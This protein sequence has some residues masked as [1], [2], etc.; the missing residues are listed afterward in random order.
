[1][2]RSLHKLSLL[3]AL[4]A[5]I[6]AVVPASAQARLPRGFIG[7]TSEDVFAGDH[8]YRTANLNL[9]A[10]ARVGLTRQTFD[11]RKIETSPGVYDLSYHDAYVAEL[12]T[13]RM[14]VLPILF[15][16]PSF[17]TGTPVTRPAYPPSSNASMARFAQVLVN[18]YGPRG[19]LWRERPWLPRT[20]IT[21]WQ[22]WNEP[23]LPVYWQGRPNARAYARMVATVGRAIRRS[24]RRAEIVTAGLPP[25]TQQGAVPLKRYVK[26]LYR[27][28][29]GRS[30]NSL[31][32]NSYAR[33]KRELGRLLG[34]LRKQMNR[35]GGRRNSLWI[36]E[37]G[38]ATSGPRSRFTVGPGGQARLIGSAY[39]LLRRDRRKLKLRG[40]VLFSWRDLR[41]YAPNFS[42]MWGLHAGLLSVDG[43]PK[44]GFYAFQR[45]AR[46]L[47]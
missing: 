6:L 30:I 16:P 13:H 23:T 44:P 9:Q 8:A 1:V 14:R 37:L 25:S 34:S 36:T 40:V 45:A 22:I 26:Q 2:R 15:N 3:V 35:S 31:A 19:S 32:I 38:W 18:R 10:S 17:H 7:I 41:P 4:V 5:A 46:R 24:D 43:Q 39:S 33:S 42:D 12:A 20:P 21:A 29:I 47:R 27:A 28:R 11:W